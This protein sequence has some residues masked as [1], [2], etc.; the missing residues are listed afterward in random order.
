[1]DVKKKL[2]E[3]IALKQKREVEQDKKIKTSE[4]TK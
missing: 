2:Q 4:K 3:A 1:M